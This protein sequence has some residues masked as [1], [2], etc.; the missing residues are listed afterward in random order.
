MIIDNI[1][2]IKG[3]PRNIKYFDKIGFKLVVG[4]EYDM[5]PKLLSK[6]STFII[7]CGC[8][9]CFMEKKLPFREYYS[10]TKEFTEPYY[11]A[12]CKT[13]KYKN[14][15]IEKYG[16]DNT[17]KVNSVK[18]SLKISLVDKY[19]VDHYSKTKEYKL[20]Y[21]ETCIGKYGVDN[22]SKSEEVKKEISN[23]KFKNSNSI[24][25]YSKLLPVEYSIIKYCT[26]NSLKSTNVVSGIGFNRNF[27]IYHDRCD[28][29]FDIFIGT[30]SDR[31][32]SKSSVC[33][34]CNPVDLSS[35]GREIELKEFLLSKNISFIDNPYNIIPPLSLDIYIP[36]LKLAIEFNG[37]YWHSEIYKDKNYHLNKTK[38]CENVGIQLIHIWEDDWVYKTDI[39]KSIILNRLG[40]SNRIYARKCQ[41]REV[42]DILIVRD[43]LN[44]NH[45]Q[46][47]S[48]SSVKI[49]LY[50]DNELVSLMVFG[51]KKKNMELVRFCNKINTNVIGGSS[52]LFKYFIDNYEFNF[53]ESFSDISMFGG[54]MY[55]NLGFKFE[56][57]T[58][59]NYH[60]VIDGI[61]K[62]RFSYNKKNLVKMGY[63]INLSESEIMKSI[64]YYKIWECGLKKWIWIRK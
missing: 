53:I 51:K 60:W 37:V 28:S 41:I 30:L 62:H 44:K 2:K 17:M 7:N 22:T 9:K 63:D 33:T 39:I 6:G 56:H 54:G 61:R 3:H 45:I 15:C 12:K 38:L 55:L 35:S 16:V 42:D 13:I 10:N 11:C 29:I 4:E 8:D 27:K 19:G 14:T 52:R 32:R 48:H 47:Y 1:V 25:K 18:D 58:P 21:K 43:F 23:T 59:V 46:G 57:N 5:D 20:K 36:E 26:D 24:E 64:G 49:G 50:Y 40:L 31:I 34:K